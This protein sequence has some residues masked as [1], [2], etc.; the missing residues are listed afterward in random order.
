MRCLCWK[1][2][3]IPSCMLV[4]C[5]FASIYLLMGRGRNVS[6][7]AASMQAVTRS[8]IERATFE[9]DPRTP[10]AV[11][12]EHGRHFSKY[13]VGKSI[14]NVPFYLLG[15]AL[16]RLWGGHLERHAIEFAISLLNPLLTAMTC[17]LIVLLCSRLG[18]A[19]SESLLLACIYGLGT[20][21]FPYAKDD[22]SEPLAA[23][24][25]TAAAC[26]A[27]DCTTRRSPGK[28]VVC[29][30][31]LG[32]AVATRHVL[33]IVAILVSI[34]LLVCCIRS[35]SDRRRM[36]VGLGLYSAVLLACAVVLGAY[37]EIRF[38]SLLE[39]GYDRNAE[40]LSNGFC[41]RPSFF[42]PRLAALLFSPGRGLFAY[43]PVLLLAV[44][45]VPSL[46][47]RHRSEAVSLGGIF[48]SMLVLHSGFKHWEGGWSWGPRFLLPVL[49]LLIPFVG[50]GLRSIRRWSG[51]GRAVADFL[52]LISILIQVS[53]VTVGWRRY[54]H[55]VEA[56]RQ[57]GV[58]V[59]IIWRADHSQLVMQ[60]PQVLEVLSLTEAERGKM[61]YEV[62]KEG[63]SARDYLQASLAL[64]LPDFW[65]VHFWRL[66][67]LRPCVAAVVA[68]L[69]A[70]TLIFGRL[71]CRRLL[72]H[73]PGIA[74]AQAMHAD[75]V[76][77]KG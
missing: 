35:G 27:H 26:C 62:P 12:G 15:K 57:E 25:M 5:L 52:I 46:Y 49:P 8:L 13:G 53:A 30:A 68:G 72:Q 42:L 16:S 64:N 65:F 14:A 19:D 38:G 3:S 73:P 39:T 71:A 32:M 24:L 45:G 18:L 33:A 23:L 58:A 6:T 21:A 55:V 41:F 56:K 70:S 36:L 4:F 75:Q 9:V 1:P 29:A 2:E 77:I 50:Y 17:A 44:V 28:A 61:R 76:A 43:M 11:E 51:T 40:G 74:A 59:D 66:G 7:D 54:L 47:R 69:L 10:G 48:L 63:I 20:I 37:N 31:M 22:M 34:H 67:L 60:W